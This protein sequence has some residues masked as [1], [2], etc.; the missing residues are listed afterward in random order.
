MI[1]V[2][3]EAGRSLKS[4]AERL[5][6]LKNKMI[7][8]V[9]ICYI[10]SNGIRSYT[11]ISMIFPIYLSLI[12]APVM[13]AAQ[14]KQLYLERLMTGTC[15]KCSIGICTP[16]SSFFLLDVTQNPLPRVYHSH[17]ENKLTYGEANRCPYHCRR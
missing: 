16:C 8:Y 1:R 13:H 17:T 9:K 10:T 12:S 3:A 15:T 11:N 2:H 5:D 7:F 6:V 4:V 14:N